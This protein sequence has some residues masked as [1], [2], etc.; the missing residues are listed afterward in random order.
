MAAAMDTYAR[1]R[2]LELID[3][4]DFSQTRRLCDLGCGAGRYAAAILRRHPQAQAWLVDLPQPLELARRLMA[5][6]GLSERVELVAGDLMDHFAPDAYDTIL[7][8]NALHHLGAEGS[9]ALLQRCLQM[10]IP[11][12]RIVIQA[13]F[14]DEGRTSP[15]WAAL[16]DLMLLALSPRG[17]NHTVGETRQWLTEAG[18]V[19]IEHIRFSLWNV[20]SSVIARRG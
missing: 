8:S 5:D 10:L 18:F 4:V 2:G 17:R 3:R 12:G 16:V 13:Q 19:D 7:I 14:L 9:R 15:R 6:E 1:T 11:G 20:C